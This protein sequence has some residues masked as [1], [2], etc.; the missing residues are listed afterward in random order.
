MIDIPSDSK[1][2]WQNTSS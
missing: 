2:L 1:H